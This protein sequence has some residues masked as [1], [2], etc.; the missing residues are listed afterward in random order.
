[1]NMNR[2]TVGVL[3]WNIEEIAQALKINA[4]DVREYFTDGR[5]VSF[6]LERRIA[7]EVLRGTLAPSEGAAFDLL[8]SQGRK[9]EVRSIS[10]GGIYFCPS[11][12]VGSGR[13][14]NEQGFQEKLSEIE[15]YVIS[16]IESFPN[17]PYW[18]VPVQQVRTW[19][20]TR[21]LGTTTKIT[22]EKALYLL[23][24]MSR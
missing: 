16:D 19:W 11:Y 9:W 5:R 20:D 18:I 2:N 14:F 17:I 23:G 1:M 4:R 24:G 22:R 21:R 15:G 7:R 3:S 12:M 13:S 6:L 8:D 10:R